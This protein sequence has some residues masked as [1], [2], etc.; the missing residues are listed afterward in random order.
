MDFCVNHLSYWFPNCENNSLQGS[1]A[2]CI[3]FNDWPKLSFI[4][5][6]QRRRLSP[7]AKISLFVAHES[8]SNST[9][10][11]PIIFTSRHGDLHKTSDL[12][13]D[14][15]E[16]TPVSPTAFSLSVHNA[17]PSLY[18]IL[19]KNKQAINAIS[20][21]Q[22]TFFMGLVDAYA[23]LTSG[24]ADEILFIH[25]DQQLPE[26]YL[27]FKD[28]I[29]FPHAVAMILSL[30]NNK[31]KCTDGEKISL[32]MTHQLSN[33][34]HQLPAA[35]AFIEWWLQKTEF[36]VFNSAQY[37]WAIDTNVQ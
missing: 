22:D 33:S 8:A 18:S 15:A 10:D 9:V 23:R 6:M 19:T 16:Q 2:E 21:G 4:P 37:Q 26:T 1:L 29:Q 34:N 13:A 12:L 36:F 31:S 32:T 35:L 7:F 24:L 27:G 5:A 25:A 14:L 11:L 30:P 3:D 17:I 28:E 20:A